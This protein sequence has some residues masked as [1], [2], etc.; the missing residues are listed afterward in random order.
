[1]NSA[2]FATISAFISRSVRRVFRPVPLSTAEPSPRPVR[3]QNEVT[4]VSKRRALFRSPT[5]IRICA[6]HLFRKALPRCSRLNTIDS[7]PRLCPHLF[8]VHQ[9]SNW[10]PSA[11]R[12]ATTTQSIIDENWKSVASSSPFLLFLPFSVFDA[13]SLV[14]YHTIRQPD[15][16]RLKSLRL[17]FRA[18][19]PPTDS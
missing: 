10:G 5:P 14:V 3:Q 4:L 13:F 15:L 12:S 8:V 1:M 6:A 18:L 16:T 2:G 9:Q 11:F 17:G 7:A 19:D